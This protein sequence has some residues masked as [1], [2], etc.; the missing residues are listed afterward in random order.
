M[1]VKETYDQVPVRVCNLKV[2]DIFLYQG[3]K[4][5]VIELNDVSVMY[6][7]KK[8]KPN[9]APFGYQNIFEFGINSQQFVTLIW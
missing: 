9:G 6:C 3:T 5:M 8:Q 2:G 1:R 7:Q 4:Y